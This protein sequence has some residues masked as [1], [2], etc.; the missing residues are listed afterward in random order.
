MTN[1]TKRR[2]PRKFGSAVQAHFTCNPYQ[3]SP[4]LYLFLRK[5]LVLWQTE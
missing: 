4:A 3:A 5:P 1:D 2:D